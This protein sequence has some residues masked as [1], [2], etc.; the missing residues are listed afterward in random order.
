MIYVLK[1][2]AE[3][4]RDTLA[5]VEGIRGLMAEYKRGM[6]EQLPKLYSQEILNNLFRHPY[7]RIEYVHRDL[8]VTRQTAAKYLDQLA[9]EG[10]VAKRRT[11]RFNY[12]VN[13]PLVALFIKDAD[14]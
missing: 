8:R 2:V 13:T 6:R 3:T 1:A 9:A 11:G 4:S 5:L 12:Y 14:E 10:F 7:T